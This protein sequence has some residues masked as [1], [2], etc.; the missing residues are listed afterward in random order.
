MGNRLSRRMAILYDRNAIYREGLRGFASLNIST[1]FLSSILFYIYFNTL[2]QLYGDA[3][4][5]A[6]NYASTALACNIEHD[7]HLLH[8]NIRSWTLPGER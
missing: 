2:L 6:N 5:V 1:N 7:A 4:R 3:S 8:T